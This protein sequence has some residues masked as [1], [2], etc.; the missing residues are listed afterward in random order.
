MQQQKAASVRPI[1]G[2]DGTK[3][4]PGAKE[5]ERLKAIEARVQKMNDQLEMSGG[6]SQDRSQLQREFDNARYHRQ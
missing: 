2:P 5:D 1:E 4:V 3:I 6:L